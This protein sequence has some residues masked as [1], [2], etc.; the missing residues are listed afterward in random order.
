[1]LRRFFSRLLG[2]FSAEGLW[3]LTVSAVPTIWAFVKNEP[4]YYIIPIAAVTFAAV[5]WIANT[6]RER[7]RAP[8]KIDLGAPT[9]PQPQPQIIN[10][11][12]NYFSQELI[13]VADLV[14]M[15]QPIIEGKVFEDCILYGPAVITLMHDRPG[16][17]ENCSLEGPPNLDDIFF[18]AQKGRYLGGVIGLR[19]CTLRRCRIVKICIVGPKEEIEAAKR[20]IQV[21]HGER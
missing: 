3:A 2:D 5:F 19:G 10:P 14:V 21:R 13:R 8:Q 11:L 12:K 17:M 7:S 9:P 15:G 20:G 4:V 18:E 6:I 1:M 16:I